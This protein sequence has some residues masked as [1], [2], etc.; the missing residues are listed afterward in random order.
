MRRVALAILWACSAPPPTTPNVV[1]LDVAFVQSHCG[2]LAA[3]TRT[4]FIDDETGNDAADGSCAV[5]SASCGPW[6]TLDR[7]FTELA[8]GDALTLARYSTTPAPGVHRSF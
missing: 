8:A 4:R 7:A 1:R 2:G 5:A 6:K 3:P